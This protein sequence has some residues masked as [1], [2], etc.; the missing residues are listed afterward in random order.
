MGKLLN[1]FNVLH[2]RTSRDYLARMTAEKPGCMTIAKKFDRE[3]WDGNRKH[4]YGGYRYDGRWQ[5]VAQA[6][7]DEY[8]L[9]GGQRVLDIGCGKG[10]L[11][12]EL[13]LLVPGL[14]V[15][16]FDISDYAIG[17][18][19]DSVRERLFAHDA[20]EVLPFGDGEFDL[21]VSLNT[22][23]NLKIFDLKRALSEMDRVGR[24]GYLVVEGY[25]NDR[26][27]F[28]LECW[29]LTC[30]SFFRPEEWIWIFSEFGYQGDYEFI[31]FE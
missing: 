6:L 28:N 15:V 18:A 1:I 25:R 4:G 19:P 7:I 16:G 5:V 27:L 14:E 24:R 17:C 23:H 10:F 9:R 3:F 8:G 13:K 2:G 31:F 29:A 11:L 12:H 22:L 26:E 20:R 30:E 21:V